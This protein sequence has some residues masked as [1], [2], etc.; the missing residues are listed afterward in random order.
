MS[1]QGTDG[2]RLKKPDPHI[3]YNQDDPKIKFPKFVRG[4]AWMTY[5]TLRSMGLSD[6]N[7]HL[8]RSGNWQ[9]DLSQAILPTYENKME[10]IYMKIKKYEVPGF[11]KREKE[12]TLILVQKLLEIIHL[13]EFG[14]QLDSEEFGS[15]DPIEHLDNPAAEFACNVYQQ[16]DDRGKNI[17]YRGKFKKSGG[18]EEPYY[19]RDNRYFDLKDSNGNSIRTAKFKVNDC[20]SYPFKIDENGLVMYIHATKKWIKNT[21]MRSAEL[22]R[23]PNG[24]GPREFASAVHALQDYFFHT[25]FIEVAINLVLKKYYNE[26]GTHP[27]KQKYL[28][29]AIYETK[30]PFDPKNPGKEDKKN[31][32]YNDRQVITTGTF[33]FADTIHSII[34]EVKDKLLAIDPFDPKKAPKGLTLACLDM[35]EYTAKDELLNIGKE[36]SDKLLQFLNARIG[37]E[38]S[39]GLDEINDAKNRVNNRIALLGAEIL[40]QTQALEALANK[41]GAEVNKI[42]SWIEDNIAIPDPFGYVDK[43]KIARIKKIDLTSEKRD[44]QQRLNEIHQKINAFDLAKGDFER[45]RD[46]II[47]ELKSGPNLSSTLYSWL[48]PD[49]LEFLKKRILDPIDGPGDQLVNAVEEFEGTINSFIKRHLE[50]TYKDVLTKVIRDVLPDVEGRAKSEINEGSDLYLRLNEKDKNDYTDA[51]KKLRAHT[52][53]QDKPISDSLRIPSFSISPDGKIKSKEKSA[54]EMCCLGYWPPSHSTIAKDHPPIHF[55]NSSEEHHEVGEWLHPIAEMLAMAATFEI[56]DVIRKYWDSKPTELSKEIDKVLNKWMS[57]P[58]D[59]INY[60]NKFLPI[61]DN[62][63]TDKPLKVK[64]SNIDLNLNLDDNEDY[65]CKKN[66]YFET[67]QNAKDNEIKITII[68]KLLEDFFEYDN[69]ILEFNKKLRLNMKLP[70]HPGS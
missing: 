60:W 24:R 18:Q 67:L 62:I 58:I 63:I 59:D 39:V 33:D 47:N 11:G 26:V 61:L 10:D 32:V 70:Y 46:N 3:I 28:D 52:V 16:I 2:F 66:T 43:F 13:D 29:T 34:G 20:C 36:A 51:A 49:P 45:L 48:C 41:I 44:L 27:D 22:G 17:D 55:S 31:L 65:F 53:I 35:L 19:L 38:I 15:Y 56:G 21:L 7:A 25:N 1:A 30:K 57:H 37:R 68:K 23:K 69:Y 14:N 9:R 42:I 5:C 8:A 40:A 54:N 6:I 4:H 12:F 64:I 50:D